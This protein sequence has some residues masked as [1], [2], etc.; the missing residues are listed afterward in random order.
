MPF[1][2]HSKILRKRCLQFLLGPFNSQEKLKTILMQNFGVTNKEHYGVLWYFLEWSIDHFPSSKNSHFQNEAKC[3]IFVVKMKFS[4]M[5]IQIVFIS[6]GLHFTSLWNRGLRP[7]MVGRALSRRSHRIIRGLWTVQRFRVTV[8]PCLKDTR[9]IRTS[10][11]YRQFALSLGKG[12]RY[13]FSEFNP[14]NTDTP[15][16]RTLSMTPSVSARINLGVWLHRRK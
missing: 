6:M 10:H 8:K 13:I 15:L 16:I 4:C 12:S 11:Y 2:C 9:L 3:K 14:L 1:V 7:L 5:R